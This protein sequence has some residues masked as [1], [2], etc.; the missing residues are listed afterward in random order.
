MKDTLVSYTLG[1]SKTSSDLMILYCQ[2]SSLI[3]VAHFLVNCISLRCQGKHI[4]ETEDVVSFIERE[5]DEIALVLFGGL[6]YFSGQ[7][8]DFKTI[9]QAGHAKVKTSQFG[10]Y[11]VF[12]MLFCL[13]LVYATLHSVVSLCCLYQS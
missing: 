2:V 7:L 6:Q 3:Y 10:L 4:I 1:S 8:F 13:S 9:A 11:I 12:Y 5:G